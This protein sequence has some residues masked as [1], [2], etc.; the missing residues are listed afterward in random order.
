MIGGAFN[1]ADITDMVRA[2]ANGLVDTDENPEEKH[3]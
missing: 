3:G 2:T 1:L